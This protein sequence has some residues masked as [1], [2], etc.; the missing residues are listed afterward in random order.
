MSLM[1]RQHGVG[2]SP[3]ASAIYAVAENAPSERY[4]V[5]DDQAAGGRRLEQPHRWRIGGAVV[6]LVH[7]ER[8]AVAGER[9]LHRDAVIGHLAFVGAVIA[10]PVAGRAI[11]G[12]VA[13]GVQLLEQSGMALAVPMNADIDELIGLPGRPRHE[14]RFRR[15]RQE[16]EVRAGLG[17]SGREFQIVEKLADMG[18]ADEIAVMR[19][20]RPDTECVAGIEGRRA[21]QGADRE[22]GC[23]L[24]REFMRREDEVRRA[25]MDVVGRH[26]L[27]GVMSPR[28]G[29]PLETLDIFDLGGARHGGER[30]DEGDMHAPRI[31]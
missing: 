7:A 14:V 22:E 1:R 9:R 28:F 17:R 21:P 29:D 5:G 18:G 16:Q 2:D 8:D 15:R 6:G 11:E 31:P 19:Q 23:Q 3:T 4:F 24:R 20:D 10:A 13:G 26:D 12:D 27:I 25:A 30:V